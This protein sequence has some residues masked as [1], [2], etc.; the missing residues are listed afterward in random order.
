L[1]RHRLRELP[2]GRAGGRRDDDQ[3]P[4]NLA[5]ERLEAGLS[6]AS[7]FIRLSSAL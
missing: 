4:L 5:A 2:V 1:H 6:P 7:R 3:R